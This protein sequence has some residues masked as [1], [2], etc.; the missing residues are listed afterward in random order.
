[1]SADTSGYNV[2]ETWIFRKSAPEDVSMIQLIANPQAFHGRAVRL[3]GFRRL[4]FEGNI[5]Y[6]HQEDFELGIY[7]NALWIN[8]PDDMDHQQRAAVDGEYAIC[9]G[10]FNAEHRG[11]MNACSGALTNIVRL[12][13][14]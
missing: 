12:E 2:A 1:M 11:H 8:V 9:D 14:W 5:L 13:G 7:K 4:R 3:F 6:F 10:I